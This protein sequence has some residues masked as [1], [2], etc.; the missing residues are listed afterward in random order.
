MAKRKRES[1]LLGFSL[2]DWTGG[3]LSPASP[4]A[5]PTLSDQDRAILDE[6]L[7][8]LARAMSLTVED[9]RGPTPAPR[10]S[11]KAQAR[12]LARAAIR[13]VT[14]LPS[15][16][17]SAYFGCNH[18]VFQ[19]SAARGRRMPEYAQLMTLLRKHPRAKPLNR[20][21]MNAEVPPEGDF[22]V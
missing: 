19:R 7:T 20:I 13:D 9:L 6:L 10:G 8:V 17:L 14:E 4:Q 1:H 12:R 15:R 21:Q 16:V 18:S 22:P 5:A 3:W 11:V 2:D